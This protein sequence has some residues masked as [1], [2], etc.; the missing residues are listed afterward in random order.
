MTV[1]IAI[2]CLI[3]GFLAGCVVGAMVTEI[4]QA[5]PEEDEDGAYSKSGYEDTQNVSTEQRSEAVYP[6]SEYRPTF[7]D[8]VDRIM[9]GIQNGDF[10]MSDPVP[11]GFFEDGHIDVARYI[12]DKYSIRGDGSDKSS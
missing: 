1:A 12:A 9:Q 6:G 3:S 4:I 10:V 5:I 8:L 11:E 7:R 2:I